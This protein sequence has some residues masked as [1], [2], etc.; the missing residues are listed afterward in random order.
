MLHVSIKTG[1]N[2]AIVSYKSLYKRFLGTI[3]PVSG[4]QGAD[5]VRDIARRRPN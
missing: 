1:H 3:D 5:V 4:G 2:R